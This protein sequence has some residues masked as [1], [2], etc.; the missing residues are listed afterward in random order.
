MDILSS[1]SVDTGDFILYDIP[2]R[3]VRGRMRLTTASSTQ[4]STSNLHVVYPV[5]TN[6]ALTTEGLPG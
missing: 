5:G 6:E 3:G 4:E 2:I 1:Y